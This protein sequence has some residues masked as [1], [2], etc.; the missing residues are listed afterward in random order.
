MR[1]NPVATLDDAEANT[2]IKLV[3]KSFGATWL[4]LPED[5]SLRTLWRRDDEVATMEL[6]NLGW[7]IQQMLRVSRRWTRRQ[8]DNIKTGNDSQRRG[9]IF[10]I[11]SLAA[12]AFK[13]KVTPAPDSNPGF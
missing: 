8:I 5:D 9:A 1:K 10:E 6:L 12:F 3:E 13:N 7:A 11:I 4:G 2:Y